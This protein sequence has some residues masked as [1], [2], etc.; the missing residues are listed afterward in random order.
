MEVNALM[1]YQYLQDIN[2]IGICILRMDTKLLKYL[3][4]ANIVR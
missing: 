1:R 4:D 2:L 3:F